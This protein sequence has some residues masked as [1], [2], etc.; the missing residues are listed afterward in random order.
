M[1]Q[2]VDELIAACVGGYLPAVRRILADD[3]TL[4]RRRNSDS[5]L[6]IHPL[7]CAVASPNVPNPSDDE[8]KVRLPRQSYC[9]A[10]AWATEAE[11]YS[12]RVTRTQFV[13][14]PVAF[15]HMW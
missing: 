3:P 4:P 6:Q 13:L 5:F 10:R 14:P 9:A 11:P 8:L 15:D 2:A 7:G 1:E 12:T